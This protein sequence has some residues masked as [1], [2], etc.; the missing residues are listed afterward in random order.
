MESRSESSSLDAFQ[1][2]TRAASVAAAR[3][4]EVS[5]HSESSSDSLSEESPAD[6][7]EEYRIHMLSLAMA[8]GLVGDHSRKR[9]S[10]KSQSLIT[11]DGLSESRGSVAVTT[12][13]KASMYAL[14][15]AFYLLGPGMPMPTPYTRKTFE[16]DCRRFGVSDY[17]KCV[18]C[19]VGFPF[20]DVLAEFET[21][22]GVSI[23]EVEDSSS[24][25]PAYAK[26]P[27]EILSLSFLKRVSAAH[28]LAG[29]RGDGSRAFTPAGAIAVFMSEP[30][31]VSSWNA[32]IGRQRL[33]D[34]GCKSGVYRVYLESCV[35]AALVRSTRNIETRARARVRSFV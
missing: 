22:H 5:S 21:A 20:E 7:M 9:A 8:W 4:S 32:E 17:V 28:D 31:A 29:R 3:A 1:S 10:S 12:A 6:L 13:C 35:M 2:P 19:H 15:S 23:T 25:Q 33:L 30:Q 14:L 27:E 34:A 16:A 18:I 26:S 24:P 11:S